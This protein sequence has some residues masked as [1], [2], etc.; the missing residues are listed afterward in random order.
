VEADIASSNYEDFHTTPFT[1]MKINVPAGRAA[2][3]S[4]A[5]CAAAHRALALQDQARIGGCSIVSD[6]HPEHQ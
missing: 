2:I 5:A 4:T 3:K 6:E 1:V